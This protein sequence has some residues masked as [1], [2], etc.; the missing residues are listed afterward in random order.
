VGRRFR[1]VGYAGDRRRP[2]GP[3]IWDGR[4]RL[5]HTVSSRYRIWTVDIVSSERGSIWVVLI[6][7]LDLGS[8]GSGRVPI[9]VIGDLI[10]ALGSRSSGSGRMILFRRSHFLK[11]PL[12]NF[13][14]NPQS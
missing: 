3:S 12:G 10:W 9:L 11:E 13:K 5:G 6:R 8:Y 1:H 2:S 14:M 4:S 7:I